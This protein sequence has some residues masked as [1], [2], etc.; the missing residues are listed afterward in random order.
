MKTTKIPFIISAILIMAITFSCSKESTPL[1]TSGTVNLKAKATL[2]NLAAKSNISKKNLS[3]LTISSFKINIKNIEFDRDM[4]G[5][6]NH[7][8]NHG[9]NLNEESNLNHNDSTYT[10]M[11][12]QGPFELDLVAN[13]TSISIATTNIPNNNFNEIKFELHKSTDPLSSI[14]GKSIEIKGEISGVPFIY[15]TS[16]EEEMKVT[17]NSTSTNIVVDG[18]TTTAIIN[19]DLSTIFGAT[20][21]IDFSTAI[22]GNGDGI[23]EISSDNIDGNVELAHLIKNLLEEDSEIENE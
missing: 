22:D 23:I 4:D 10:N 7:N 20:S 21:L 13:D 9:S 16:E 17:F 14:F 2:I 12:M 8:S 3:N 18:S 19:F 15:W 6:S 5:D 1:T 11:A